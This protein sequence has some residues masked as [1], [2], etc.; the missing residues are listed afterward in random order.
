MDNSRWSSYLSRSICFTMRDSWSFNAGM[1]IINR[2]YEKRISV[3]IISSCWTQILYSPITRRWM[4][5]RLMDSIETKFLR[6]YNKRRKY[7]SDS[8]T[9]LFF[10]IGFMLIE[11][12]LR[13]QA[14]RLLI[15]VWTTSVIF[16]REIYDLWNARDFWL[17]SSK[18]GIEDP[19]TGCL[20]IVIKKY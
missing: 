20:A 8:T 19:R 1:S 5:K 10:T 14:I 16:A 12:K 15:W 6:V 18:W 7:P 13:G 3:N 2:N 11:C 4:K 17:V 9:L